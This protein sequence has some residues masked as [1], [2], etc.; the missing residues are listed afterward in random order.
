[1][2][3]TVS[4][5]NFVQ[6]PYLKKKLTRRLSFVKFMQFFYFIGENYS[7]NFVTFKIFSQIYYFL[8]TEVMYILCIVRIVF[9]V[10]KS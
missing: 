2:N 6:F 9:L 8:H 4:I 7:R 5:V 10:E 3:L 1:M